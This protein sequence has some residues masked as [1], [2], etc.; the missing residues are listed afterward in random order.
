MVLIF[1]SIL[2]VLL[3][4]DENVLKIVR[5]LLMLTNEQIFSVG[6]AL[7]LNCDQ[8]EAWMRAKPMSFLE[9]MIVAWLQQDGGVIPTLR[10]LAQSLMT[11]NRHDIAG[12][13]M[14]IG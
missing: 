13:I 4:A 2:S 1:Y 12:N 8:L 11:V 10:R 7:G 14:G 6:R 3:L 5:E 9:E